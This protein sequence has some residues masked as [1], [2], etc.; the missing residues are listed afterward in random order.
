MGNRGVKYGQERGQPR[1]YEKSSAGAPNSGGFTQRTV[2]STDSHIRFGKPKF[3]IGRRGSNTRDAPSVGH[4]LT[5]PVR[6]RACAG[7][8]R[9]SLCLVGVPLSGRLSGDPESQ[10]TA[11][12]ICSAAVGFAAECRTFV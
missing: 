6:R 7:S 12:A 2:L 9:S 3:A 10:R 5:L 4:A 8:G 11:G 1:D